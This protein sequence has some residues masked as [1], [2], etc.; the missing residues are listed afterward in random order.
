MHLGTCFKKLVLVAALAAVSTLPATALAWHESGHRIVARIAWDGLT[1]AQRIFVSDLLVRHPRFAEDFVGRMPDAIK[2]LPEGD[3]ERRKWVFMHAAIWPDLL[4]GEAQSLAKQLAATGDGPDKPALERRLADVKKYNNSTWHY[5]NKPV[6]LDPYAL[7]PAPAPG[8]GPRPVG[9]QQALPAALKELGDRNLPA[10]RRAVA[11]AWVVHL[12]GDSHQPLHTV[13]LF[14]AN[15]LP[16]GDLGGNKLIVTEPASRETPTNLHAVW[17]G[18][19]GS[20]AKA[21]PALTRQIV[22]AHPRRKLEAQLAAPAG[23]SVEA[24]VNLWLDESYRTADE[25]TYDASIRAAVL[26]AS[27]T[28]TPIALDRRYLAAAKK[29]AMRRV[30]LAGY[31]LADCIAEAQR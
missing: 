15:A 18:L 13:A 31:R 22:A 9:I 27:P 14:A 11:L 4:K 28:A 25:S 1:P 29:V 10:E 5:D 2:A 21:E 24:R 8:P 7:P 30:A 20:D 19:F 26:A 16:Q 23:Q 12:L 17:D 6:Y 3:G